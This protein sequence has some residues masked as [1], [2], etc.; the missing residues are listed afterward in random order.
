[1][2]KNRLKGN[3]AA[4]G[5]SQS[6]LWFV[7]PKRLDG[8]G[9]PLGRGAVWLGDDVKGGVPSEPF[10]F[11][12]FDKRSMFL[13]HESPE[14]IPVRV[15][16]DRT[17]NGRWTVLRRIAVPARGSVWMDFSPKETGA[18]VRLSP[19]RDMP[20]ATAFFHYRSEDKRG[21]RANS[22]FA[23][24]RRT[25]DAKASGGLL[26]V[27]GGSASSL[28]FL[29]RN[30]NGELGCY[31]LDGELQLKPVEDDAGAAWMRTNVA[32][33]QGV[34][35]ADNA[36]VLYVDDQ[37]KRWRLPRN[38]DFDLPGPLGPERVC[39]EVCTER[40]LL[41]V[42]G[43][44]YE[45]PAENAGGF[46]KV[47]PVSTHNRRIVDF[48]SY[49]GLLVL[50][51]IRNGAR[52]QR[53]IQSEDNQC[54][55]WVGAVD[56]LWEFGKPRGQGGPWKESAVRANEPSD[57]Y[58]MT[59]YDRKRV[60]LSHAGSG[61]VRMRI[62]ADVSG[63]GDWLT[64]RDFDVPPGKRVEHRFPDAFGAYWVRVVADQSTT[65]SALFTYD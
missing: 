10:L 8:F 5:K 36:S 44:F 51:G 24:I 12:G 43:T 28:R 57:P 19:D 39:R 18:W 56:D 47:R 7:E 62:Q 59:G 29:A 48:A 60:T 11:S 14:E 64:Y 17:G 52:G 45:L 61:T 38:G 53:I 55:L 50:S 34:I 9:P 49:R 3:L 6:N 32:V 23:G 2:N 16:V 1:L 31:D 15:E 46:A 63:A 40:N 42:H 30:A 54:A 35:Q 26:H 25:A 13:A 33:P 65:A 27:R 21:S 37:G 4:P 41:N 22:I 58:L 20:G